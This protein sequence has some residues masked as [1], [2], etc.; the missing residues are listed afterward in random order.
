MQKRNGA[1][2]FPPATNLDLVPRPR[3]E[4]KNAL[5]VSRFILETPEECVEAVVAESLE[6]PLDV[7]PRQSAQGV[8]AQSCVFHHHGPTHLVVDKQ[9]TVDAVGAVCAVGSGCSVCDLLHDK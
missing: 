4:G 3:T 5:R 7:G 9:K 1:V 2:P 6:E 8:E